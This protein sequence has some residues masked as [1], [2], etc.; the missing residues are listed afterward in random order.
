MMFLYLA[1]RLTAVAAFSPRNV[2]SSVLWSIIIPS[3]FPPA[4]H[5]DFLTLQKKVHVLEE[6]IEGLSPGREIQKKERSQILCRSPK[7]LWCTVFKNLQG[8]FH[9]T[10]NLQAWGAFNTQTHW[11]ESICV[12]YCQKNGLSSP[13]PS[14]TGSGCQLCV[15]FPDLNHSAWNNPAG[16]LPGLGWLLLFLM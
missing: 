7:P 14:L 10:P 5:Q 2:L 6:S 3:T 16:W 13:V 15:S 12:S 1:A 11:F 4:A 8:I 9:G